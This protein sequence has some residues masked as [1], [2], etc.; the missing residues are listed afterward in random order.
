MC[1]APLFIPPKNAIIFP[2]LVNKTLKMPNIWEG[3]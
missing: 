1:M 2:N 3:G